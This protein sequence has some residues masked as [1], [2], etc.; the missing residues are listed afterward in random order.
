VEKY[1]GCEK[2]R[3]LLRIL[4]YKTC[5]KLREKM[6]I[7]W[8]SA[9]NILNLLTLFVEKPVEKVNNYFSIEIR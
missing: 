9:V 6:W 8:K 7:M 5:G 1:K 3:K 4:R 2:L